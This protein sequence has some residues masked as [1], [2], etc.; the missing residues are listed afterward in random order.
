MNIS[1]SSV[2]EGLRFLSRAVVGVARRCRPARRR[3]DKLSV[4]ATRLLVIIVL[5]VVV[6]ACLR[7]PRRAERRHRHGAVVEEFPVAAAEVPE[8]SATKVGIVLKAARTAARRC[9]CRRIPLLVM[10]QNVVGRRAFRYEFSG[11]ALL[12]LLCVTVCVIV[13]VCVAE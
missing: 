13:C 1:G 12:G 8:D 4:D 3:R 9:S 11:V 2:A 7:Q 5:V 6:V 10:I